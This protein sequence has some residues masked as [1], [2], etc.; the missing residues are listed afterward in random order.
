LLLVLVLLLA[1]C[2]PE[3]QHTIDLV[4]ASRS[5]AGLPTLL[6]RGDAIDKAQAW[7]EHMA[8][9]GAIGHSDLPAGM[10]NDWKALGENVGVGPSIDA[11][12][13]AFLASPAHRANILDPR[14]NSLG[15]GVAVGAD[16]RTYVVQVFAQY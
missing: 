12:Q 2:T 7:A 15:T 10:I 8:A 14:Y 6:P 5:T 4:N 16:G 11:V 9:N 3:Q 13:E 1:A